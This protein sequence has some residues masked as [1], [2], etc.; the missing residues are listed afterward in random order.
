[1]LIKGRRPAGDVSKKQILRLLQQQV[2]DSLLYMEGTLWCVVLRKERRSNHWKEGKISFITRGGAPQTIAQRLNPLRETSALESLKV[3]GKG[4]IVL[5]AKREK[6]LK[7]VIPVGEK[8]GRGRNCLAHD[9]R[10]G[11]KEKSFPAGKQ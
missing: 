2:G 10:G 9:A 8:K 6:K 11:D 5:S 7:V 1:L 3:S 4:T